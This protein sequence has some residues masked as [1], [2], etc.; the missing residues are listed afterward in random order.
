DAEKA[1][2]IFFDKRY[3]KA[4][5]TAS[6]KALDSTDQE[7]LWNSIS[8]LIALDGKL[9]SEDLVKAAKS[10]KNSVIHDKADE[11]RQLTVEYNAICKGLTAT[12]QVDLNLMD[13]TG[14]GCANISRELPLLQQRV[15]YEIARTAMPA[16]QDALLN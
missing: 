2:K 12:G 3:K 4:F 1:L 11:V 7:T 10:L 16:Y 5:R 13:K 6:K 14:F 8:M 15:Q 9:N